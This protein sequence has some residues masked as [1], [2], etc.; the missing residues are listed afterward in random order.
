[1]KIQGVFSVKYDE[2][3]FKKSLR[4]ICFSEFFNSQFLKS[5]GGFYFI[6]GQLRLPEYGV[7]VLNL[8]FLMIIITSA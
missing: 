1:M 2:H 4:E 5:W 8:E 7:Q 6:T 3:N